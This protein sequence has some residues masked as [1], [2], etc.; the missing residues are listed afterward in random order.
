MNKNVLIFCA[1]SDDQILGPGGTTAKLSAQGY[2]VT[3]VIFTN[4]ELSHPWLKRRITAQVREDEARS[5]DL[6]VGGK[7]VLFLGITEP[8]FINEAKAQWVKEKILHILQ[9][10]KPVKI[11][12]HSGDD[13]H[14][15]HRAVKDTVLEVYDLHKFN[16]DV[17]TFDI[18]NFFNL[19]ERGLPRLY[20]DT[21]ETFGRKIEALKC[22]KSQWMTMITLLWSV[23]ARA[24]LKGIEFRTK[25]AERFYKVR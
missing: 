5:A 14:A 17:Y 10:Y 15:G 8:N 3:N 16:C 18:W 24:F 2:Q 22:F 23:Y 1:H 13:P 20:V 21:S 4:G 12:L 11:F 25:Y 7:G 9:E 19:K 6:V